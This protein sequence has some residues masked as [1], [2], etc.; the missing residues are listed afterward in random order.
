MRKFARIVKILLAG[1][2]LLVVMVHFFQE[3]LI[4]LPTVLPQDYTYSFSEPFK[5]VF[6]TANDGAVLN[7]LHFECKNPKGVILYFHGNAG[8]LSR[9]GSV[10]APFIEKGFDVVVM[11]YRTYGKSTG[12]LS[13]QALFRDGQLF[14]DY[15]LSHYREDEMTLYGRSLGT[16]IAVKLASQNQPKQLVLESPFYSL[17][18]VARERFPYF[19]VKWLI[20]YPMRSYKY[21]QEAR[22]PIAIFHGTDDS[23][24]PYSS[25][26]RLYDGVPFKQKN[27]VTIAGGGHNNLVEFKAYSS[28]IDQVLGLNHSNSAEDR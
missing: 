18:D 1:Y 22:C 12:K 28:G 21:I 17:E 4:F 13:E 6:L 11:D 26:K 20:R 3:K 2:I 24:V 10:V 7:G 27:F 5:E 14:Y 8:D 23:V 19:P 25:G 9:W 15:V 16:G